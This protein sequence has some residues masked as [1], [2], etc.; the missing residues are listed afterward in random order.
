MWF[1]D[2]IIKIFVLNSL[3]VNEII[4]YFSREVGTVVKE[5]ACYCYEAI[6]YCIESSM[7]PFNQEYRV[8]CYMKQVSKVSLRHGLF[9]SSAAK[10]YFK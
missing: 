2:G 9:A 6:L 5:C 4:K 3:Q 10:H 8:S 7:G 1:S